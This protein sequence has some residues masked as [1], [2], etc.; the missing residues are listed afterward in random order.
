MWVRQ[1]YKGRKQK[2]EFHLL[3][4]EMRLHD[5]TLFFQYFRMSPT[6]YE[7]LLKQI[8]PVIQ[9]Q[10]EKREPIGPSERLSVVLRYTFTGDSQKTI[11]SSFRKP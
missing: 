8:A 7:D 1:I 5:H 6:Q 10:S 11:V 9:K 4:K 2:G 3:I